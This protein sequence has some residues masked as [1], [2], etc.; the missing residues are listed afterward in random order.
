MNVIKVGQGGDTSLNEGMNEVCLPGKFQSDRRIA[1]GQMVPDLLSSKKS[2]TP[3]ANLSIAVLLRPVNQAMQ[4]RWQRR[5]GLGQ[6]RAHQ[7]DMGRQRRPFKLQGGVGVDEQERCVPGGHVGAAP[8]GEGEL[9][10]EGVPK[11]PLQEP[12]A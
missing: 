1:A 5:G 2:Q 8:H 6:E 3:A 4:M 9:G 7:S 10:A 12:G 11:L